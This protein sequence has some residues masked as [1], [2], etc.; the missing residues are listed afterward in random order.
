MGTPILNI[1]RGDSLLLMQITAHASMAQ[2]STPFFESEIT[3]K[4]GG[5]AISVCAMLLA[6]GRATVVRALQCAAIQLYFEVEVAPLYLS[7][8]IRTRLEH[9]S[10]LGS[11]ARWYRSQP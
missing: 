8:F 10:G 7:A 9:L 11:L 6:S 5:K 3:A 2:W 1:T 4:A